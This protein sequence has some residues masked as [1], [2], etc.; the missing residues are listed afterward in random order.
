MNIFKKYYKNKILIGFIYLTLLV[1]YL[2]H[3]EIIYNYFKYSNIIGSYK[4]GKDIEMLSHSM[5]AILFV[6]IPKSF[7]FLRIILG[8]IFKKQK[9]I[10]VTSIKKPI[11]PWLESR[12]DY[13]V[14]Y[15]KESSKRIHRFVVLNDVYSLKGKKVGNTYEV[16]YYQFSKVV[17]EM[18][19]AKKP[20]KKS[21]TGDGTTS[22]TRKP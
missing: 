12:N 11:T 22:C 7:E 5:I 8:L 15:A 6:A 19:K 17:T 4:H 10:I 1:M 18:K 20:N 2:V 13:V 9:T 21:R 14:L 16:T 3:F